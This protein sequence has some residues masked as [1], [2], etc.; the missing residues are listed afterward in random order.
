MAI[1]LALLSMRVEWLQF[2]HEA[3]TYTF[4]HERKVTA[5]ITYDER[6]PTMSKP[7]QRL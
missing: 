4:S 6:A 1:L 3:K 2:D 7:N 5:H